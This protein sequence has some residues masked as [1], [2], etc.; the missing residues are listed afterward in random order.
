MSVADPAS[1]SGEVPVALEALHAFEAKAAVLPDSGQADELTQYDS[2]VHRAAFAA[3]ESARP[4]SMVR[5]PTFGEDVAA[6]RQFYRRHYSHVVEYSG[7][8]LPSD[9]FTM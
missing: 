7:S 2:Q 8:R 1:S 6:E 3:L 9:S 4:V 5:P